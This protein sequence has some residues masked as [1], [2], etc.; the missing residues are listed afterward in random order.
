MS[1]PNFRTM[2]N[3]SLF[4]RTDDEDAYFIMREIEYN[5]NEL[6]DALMF[7]KILVDG[8]HYYGL[9]F[10]V[11]ENYDPNELDNEDCRYYFDM[12]RSVAIRRYNSEINK[13]NRMLRRMAKEWGFEEI[14]C[15]AVFGN[16]EAVY[17]P[18]RNNPR[19]RIAQA[20]S[21]VY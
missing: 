3:F 4:V 2:E 1:C 8:G 11:E 14:Y 20:V 21:P 12:F 19:A 7:H 15:A 9:Q 6:N 16:G 5:L 18:V 10:Y 17:A 13:I